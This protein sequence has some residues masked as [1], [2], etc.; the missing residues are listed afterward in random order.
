MK[1]IV[2]S[3]VLCFCF[4]LQAE[5]T[6]KTV[7]NLEIDSFDS[8]SLAYIFLSDGT[9]WK[10]NVPL[11]D[12]HRLYDIEREFVFGK[13]VLAIPIKCSSWF[14]INGFKGFLSKESKEKLPKVNL[15]EKCIS[16]QNWL[17][18]SYSY[19][20]TLTDGSNW[21]LDS[22]VAPFWNKGDSILV[23]IYDGKPFLINVDAWFSESQGIDSR[24]GSSQGVFFSP[25]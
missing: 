24:I 9:S 18:T 17:Y 8:S 2:L 23:Q 13:E 12:E 1:T 19:K 25:E 5:I 3:F 22:Y 6:N 7:T 16:N 15:I 10:I 21:D 14:R 20:I 4:N 11:E